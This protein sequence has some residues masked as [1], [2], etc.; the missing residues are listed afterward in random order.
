MAQSGLKD[1]RRAIVFI[2]PSRNTA[3]GGIMAIINL[4]H[5]SERLGKLHGA[6]V[7]VCTLPGDRP[8]LRYTKFANDR[9]LLNF[10]TLCKALRPDA[11]VL[12]HIPEIF[13]VRF[14]E[15]AGSVLA[16][17]QGNWRF[18]ILLQNIDYIPC[19]EDVY[20]LSR[21]GP[22]SATT[23]HFAYSGAKT[24]EALGC[25]VH[26]LTA[27]TST[28]PYEIKPFNEKKNIIIVS[29][30][31]HEQRRAVL[32]EF[33]RKLPEFQFVTISR[34]TYPA[35]RQLIASAKFSLTFGEGFD[36]YFSETS[37]CGGIGCAVYNSRFFT[38]DFA[39]LPFIY[40]SWAELF[41][42]MP[43]DV[44]AANV[45]GTLEKESRRIRAVLEKYS[46]L[47]I[48]QVNLAAYY[49]QYFAATPGP[50]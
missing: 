15:S 38:E 34:M 43:D 36:A 50:Q 33:K 19:K 35:Y 8:L 21:L 42:R 32:S 37:F 23:A 40:P 22:V 47:E 2:T 26:H 49:R 10:S 46:S 7:F 9:I 3:N 11:E 25:P 14:V 24:A 28:T 44:R 39:A 17:R 27:W 45:P 6:K 18:N 31:L 4:A 16:E 13:T 20:A 41:R 30:D 1:V 48:M 5:E 12:V 29:P